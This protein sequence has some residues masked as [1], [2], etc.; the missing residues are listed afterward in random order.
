MPGALFPQTHRSPSGEHQTEDWASNLHT[1]SSFANFFPPNGASLSPKPCLPDPWS[2]TPNFPSSCPAL[3]PKGW[4][5]RSH[6]MK[7]KGLKATPGRGLSPLYNLLW[8][9]P[10]H[11]SV[12]GSLPQTT[13]FLP[14]SQEAGKLGQPLPF[15]DGKLRP[16]DV[17]ARQDQKVS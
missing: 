1:S 4:R 10:S 8:P 16:R 9:T 6:L 3:T 17:K 2:L 7:E 15:Y 14:K 5:Q 13:P 12:H 11:C